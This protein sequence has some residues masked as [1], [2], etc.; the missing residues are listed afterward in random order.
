MPLHETPDGTVE[1]LEWGEGPEQIILLHAAASS[2]HALTGFAECLARPDRRIIAP[3]LNGYGGTQMRTTGGPIEDHL[4]VAAAC[5]DLYPAD[6]RVVLGHSM[7]GLVA[8]LSALRRDPLDAL[9]LF[10]PI[11]IGVLDFD[12][13]ED[14]AA[15]AWDRTIVRDFGSFV[16][17]GEP[18]RGIAAFVEAW[19]EFPWDAIPDAVR[20]RLVGAAPRLAAETHAVGEQEVELGALAKFSAP[21]LLLQGSTSPALPSRVIR[22]LAQQLRDVECMTLNELGHMGPIMVPTAVADAF[23]TF[24]SQRLNTVK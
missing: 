14:R 11:V 21:V 18:E 19:N 24:L 9:I 6:R 5:L 3:M 16:A 1:T 7:G 15:C 12:D 13:A 4:T 10:E 23:E 22:R 17:A 2:P 8:L 20:A